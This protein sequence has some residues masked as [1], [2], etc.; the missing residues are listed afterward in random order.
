MLT[1]DP[2][3]KQMTHQ[4]QHSRS[5]ALSPTE[6]WSPE[7]NRVSRSP[8][9]SGIADDLLRL[10]RDHASFNTAATPLLDLTFLRRLNNEEDSRIEMLQTTQE[11]VRERMTPQ[12][13]LHWTMVAI[14]LISHAMP[15]EPS[16]GT[17]SE[18]LRNELLPHVLRC[19]EHAQEFETHLLG[20]VLPQYLSMLLSSLARAGRELDYIDKLVERSGDGYYRCLAAKWRAYR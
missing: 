2:S 12:Q 16:S 13:R 18:A 20:P 6:R 10:F 7:G 19:V 8:Q 9:E 3:M 17:G 15:E 14:R 1:E 4:T 11:F 5:R